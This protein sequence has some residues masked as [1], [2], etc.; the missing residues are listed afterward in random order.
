MDDPEALQVA[1]ACLGEFPPTNPRIL[2]EAYALLETAGNA[3]K[4]LTVAE[5]IRAL[6]HDRESPMLASGRQQ[7]WP[8]ARPE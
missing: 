2:S 5:W 6:G 1:A 4:A 3:G 7:P 8:P